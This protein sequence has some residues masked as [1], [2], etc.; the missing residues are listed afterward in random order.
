MDKCPY[1]INYHCSGECPVRGF[2]L[3]SKL[4]YCKECAFNDCGHCPDCL[5]FVDGR[6]TED[7]GAGFVFDHD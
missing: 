2:D 3:G 1:F 6:C 4:S 7:D 5:F